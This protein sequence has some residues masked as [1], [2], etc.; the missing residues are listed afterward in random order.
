M[1]DNLNKIDF[2]AAGNSLVLIW[3]K[4][5]ITRFDEEVRWKSGK[6]TFLPPSEYRSAVIAIEFTK[7]EFV[8]KLYQPNEKYYNDFVYIVRIYDPE[9]EH[10]FFNKEY[11]LKN[12]WKAKQIFRAKMLVY[13]ETDDE[14][15]LRGEKQMFRGIQQILQ[16]FGYI[17]VDSLTIRF[18]KNSDGLKPTACIL[19]LN[20]Q[21]ILFESGDSI[22]LFN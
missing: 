3:K 1:K 14:I 20:S 12:P 6:L 10:D 13:N 11:L 16:T 2:M 9:A 4:Y 7:Q 17:K 8:N 19:H 5:G 22:Y 18:I 15:V 21:E